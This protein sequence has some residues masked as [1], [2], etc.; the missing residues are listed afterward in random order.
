MMSNSPRNTIEMQ[1]GSQLSGSYK[2]DHGEKE[3]GEHGAVTK[4]WVPGIY[5]RPKVIMKLLAPLY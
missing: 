4:R 1:K 2:A 3:R 5:K